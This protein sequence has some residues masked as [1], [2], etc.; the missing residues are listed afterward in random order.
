MSNNYT[1]DDV[2][3]AILKVINNYGPGY[4]YHQ[5]FLIGFTS[6]TVAVTETGKHVYF[7]DGIKTME[8]TYSHD[9]LK[10]GGRLHHA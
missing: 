7:Y 2:R 1:Y 8:F 6:M 5:S 4:Y 9:D 10:T 3:K